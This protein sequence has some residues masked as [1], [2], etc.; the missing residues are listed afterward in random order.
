MPRQIGADEIIISTRPEGGSNWLGRH[1]VTRARERL[2][3][4]ITHIV[5]DTEV[6]IRLET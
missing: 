2:A 1:V 4:P 3:L 5:I 6:D